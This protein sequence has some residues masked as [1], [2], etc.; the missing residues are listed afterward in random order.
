M[1]AE[2]RNLKHIQNACIEHPGKLGETQ[3]LGGATRAHIPALLRMLL[4][5]V[6]VTHLPLLF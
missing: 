6:G 4:S 5:D 3:I 2:V 1:E